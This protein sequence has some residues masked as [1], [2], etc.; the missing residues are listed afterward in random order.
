M[1][2]FLL[3]ALLIASAWLPGCGSLPFAGGGPSPAD[4]T[5]ELV[6]RAAAEPTKPIWPFRIAE[7]HVAAGDAAAAEESLREALARDP[8]HAPSLSLLG[9]VYWD[10]QRHEEAIRLL[11]GAPD[12]LE[13]RAELRV[14]L[15]LHYDA[16]DRVDRSDSLLAGSA[17]S[18]SVR[19]WQQL[20]GDDF[21]AADDIARRALDDDP[22]SAVDHNNW[23]ITRLYA[24]EP[25][26]ARK[27][28]LTAME[29]DPRLPGPLYNLA[30]V[31][32]FYRFDEDSARDW[33]R[34]YLEL[35]RDDPDGLA[36]ILAV[37]VATRAPGPDE[38]EA[39]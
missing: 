27:S 16:L 33:F 34:R 29:L 14:A 17:P 8:E 28:F 12:V 13:A 32:R 31:D 18:S 35:A 7:R 23:G 38:E 36:E 25:E 15:A 19:A 39:P 26:E 1:R 30:I 9:K 22:D 24:G 4:G 3:P 21:G 20:R 5:D 2:K 6:A 37:E 10:Q 11:E